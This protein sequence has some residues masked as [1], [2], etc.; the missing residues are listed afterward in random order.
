MAQEM[1]T[2]NS[3]KF[4]DRS[5]KDDEKGGDVVV[6]VEEGEMQDED[7]SERPNPTIGFGELAF[8]MASLETSAAR[9]G[10]GRRGEERRGDD[11]EA[12]RLV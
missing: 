9:A 3:E 5:E 1:H 12:M 7:T 8:L 2:N 11:V 6:V 4:K 10:E